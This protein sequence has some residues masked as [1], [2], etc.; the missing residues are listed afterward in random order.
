MTT[1]GTPAPGR[2]ILHV[3]SPK[4]GTSFVQDTLFENRDLLRERGHP[5]TPRTGTTRT[6]WPRST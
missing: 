4:T 6:S 3:G 1:T 2:V 5:A